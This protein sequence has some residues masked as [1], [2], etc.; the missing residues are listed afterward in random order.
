MI[1]LDNLLLKLTGS[2]A[3]WHRDSKLRLTILRANDSSHE[4]PRGEEE[5]EDAKG[6]RA[7]TSAD[8]NKFGAS[9]LDAAADMSGGVPSILM[10]F[11]LLQTRCDIQR[12]MRAAL[13][14]RGGEL[15]ACRLRIP[16]IVRSF[17]TAATFELTIV[18]RSLVA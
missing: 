10:L 18:E 17:L 1:V 16:L 2:D 14:T 11:D 7:D 5:H 6:Q 4:R 15:T 3:S 9:Q 12:Q 8:F 13:L